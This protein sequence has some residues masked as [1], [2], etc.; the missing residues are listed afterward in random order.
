MV[1]EVKLMIIFAQTGE[2]SQDPEIDKELLELL[3]YDEH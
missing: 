1:Q 2:Q 3:Q